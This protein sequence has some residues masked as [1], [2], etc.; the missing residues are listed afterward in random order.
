MAQPISLVPPRPA[1]SRMAEHL[2]AAPEAHAEAILSALDL[3]QVLHDRGVLN[4]LRGMA[5]AGDQL[6]EIVTAA[7]DTPEAIRGIRNFLLLTKFFASIPPDVLNGL[8][9]TAVEGADREKA[10]RA[11]GLLHLLRRM[12]SEDSRH[13]IAVVLD[14]LESVGKAL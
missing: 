10:Q 1:D 2:R 3:L 9:E 14:L 12:N 8:V 11:P 5:G 13:A 6:L 4:L 7:T